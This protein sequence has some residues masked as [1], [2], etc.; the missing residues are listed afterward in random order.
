[1]LK[2]PEIEAVA[3][4]VRSLAGLR[5]D[6]GADLAAGQEGLR[7]QLRRL[8]RRG[9][10]G[11]PRCR[12]SNL[13][14]AIWLYGSDRAAIIEGVWNGRG[15]VMPAWAGRL[16]DTTIKALA[17]YVHALGGGEN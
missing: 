15:G 7:R 16:D 14:D 9:R 6:P 17:I 11:Q 13:T 12:R 1:M 8:S 5:A 10:Q 2:R 4:Y 3:D